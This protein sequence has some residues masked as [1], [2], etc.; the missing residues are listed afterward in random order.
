MEIFHGLEE[1]SRW[2][3]TFPHSTL[4]LPQL[5]KTSRQ[6]SLPMQQ[7]TSQQNGQDFDHMSV[8]SDE[9][10]DTD[11]QIDKELL[12]LVEYSQSNSAEITDISSM[13]SDNGV[14]R[15]L[16][17]S[18]R[19]TKHSLSSAMTKEM[20][21][22]S[23]EVVQNS[24]PKTVP[25]QVYSASES[26]GVA[27]DVS[28]MVSNGNRDKKVSVIRKGHASSSLKTETAD[29]DPQMNESAK[30]ADSSLSAESTDNEDEN[31]VVQ[32]EDFAISDERSGRR[33]DVVISHDIFRET[34]TYP[35]PGMIHSTPHYDL[36]NGTRLPPGEDFTNQK[37]NFSES[38][39]DSTSLW[40]SVQSA[41]GKSCE[42]F[43][44]LRMTHANCMCSRMY[45]LTSLGCYDHALSVVIVV[46]QQ[47]IDLILGLATENTKVQMAN[48]WIISKFSCV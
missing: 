1:D 24:V 28:S 43:F 45:L 27:S 46:H 18:K 22:S 33:S 35:V 16:S 21:R 20:N 6:K 9:F 2:E 19:F 10:S 29:S 26:S 38:F 30:E 11:E 32:N 44:C 31:N 7:V 42:H 4:S 41:E 40:D 3:T 13:V 48:G 23:N 39:G 14:D 34:I 25:L 8:V 47:S 15:K 36:T 12:P 37:I 17:D 5:G